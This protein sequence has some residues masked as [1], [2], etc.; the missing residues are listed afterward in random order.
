[1]VG[2]SG[3]KAAGAVVSLAAHSLPTSTDKLEEDLRG[4]QPGYPVGDWAA[5]WESRLDGDATSSKTL[6]E[7]VEGQWKP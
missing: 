6:L 1:M 3:V 7:G 5:C 4:G 2:S